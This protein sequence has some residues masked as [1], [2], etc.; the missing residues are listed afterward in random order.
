ME[1]RWVYVVLEFQFIQSI[2]CYNW[3][4]YFSVIALSVE[5]RVCTLIF[6]AAVVPEG[7]Q[8]ATGPRRGTL[9]PLREKLNNSSVNDIR[10]GNFEYS[11][12][13]SQTGEWKNELSA[14][15]VNNKP[16]KNFYKKI[17]ENNVKTNEKANWHWCGWASWPKAIIISITF[18]VLWLCEFRIL[19][20]I[21]TQL[22]TSLCA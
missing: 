19:R 18:V 13:F 14:L 16:G 20:T 5:F 21:Q 8:G 7:R 11:C 17:G 10:G 2:P 6:S 1:V 15:N 12:L 9:A 3:P 22:Q 4:A